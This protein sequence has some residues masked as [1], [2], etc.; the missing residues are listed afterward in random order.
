MEKH[1]KTIIH[2]TLD[3]GYDFFVTNNY[4]EKFHFRIST[5]QVP[6]GWLSEAI[7]VVD[8]SPEK[9][10]RVFHF[11]SD[12]DVDIEK[13][14]LSLKAK[15]KRGINQKHLQVENGRISISDEQI[16]RGRISWGEKLTDTTFNT[17]FEIDGRRVTIE[18][19][20]EMLEGYGSFNFKFQIFDSCDETE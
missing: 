16:L 18:K 7:E 2:S 1:N 13:A 17:F 14:E 15:I 3:S 20:I 6:S 10:C 8:Y 5:F 4:G 11:L 9:E 12:F 19:F